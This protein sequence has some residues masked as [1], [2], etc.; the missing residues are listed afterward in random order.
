MKRS[1][2]QLAG[3]TLLVSLP[4]KWVDANGVKKGDELELVEDGHKITINTEAKSAIETATLDADS[5]GEQ[6]QRYVF[7]L[8]KKGIDEIKINYSD[9]KVADMIRDTLLS[10]TVGYEIVSQ[11]PK[12]CT[13]KLITSGNMTEFDSLLRRTFLLLLSM[14]DEMVSSIKNKDFDHLTKTALLEQPNNRLTTVCRRTI[15]K[16]GTESY[17][18]VGPI[19]YIVE[20]LENI[21]DEYKHFCNNLAR[22]K[23][24]PNKTIRPEILEILDL[25]NTVMRAF[26]ETFYKLDL[27]KLELI[28]NARKKIVPV[29]H[30]FVEHKKLTPA[31]F[32]VLHHSIS[33]VERVYCMIGPYLIL[34]N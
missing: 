10:E 19:Y 5:V 8:Y 23:E 34:N 3:R 31:E 27:K 30:D 15:N 29:G 26:Y 2:I 33:I 13:V 9:P 21:S 6:I 28:T 22:I 7:A 18:K 11:T 12:S 4:A 1:V 14:S 16:W 20:E 25:T 17:N 32:Y 24:A